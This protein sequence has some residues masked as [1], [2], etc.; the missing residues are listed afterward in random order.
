MC[1]YTYG[2]PLPVAPLPNVEAVISYGVT[3]IPPQK[4]LMGIPL[5]G[6]DWKIPYVKGTRARSLS[7]VE[8]VELALQYGTDIQYD[9]YQQAP[10]F[11][12]TEEGQQHVVWFENM[13]SINAKLDLIKNYGLAGASLWN[14]IRDFPQF[15]MLVNSL[16]NI[17]R[18]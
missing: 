1:L 18:V 16:F 14:I 10:F 6:Y 4:I 2:P 9:D 17:Q 8:A 15:Y 12:Y 7:P 11:Y 13:R 5:Y 3:E